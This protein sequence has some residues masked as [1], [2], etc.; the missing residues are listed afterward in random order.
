[1]R[2]GLKSGGTIQDKAKRL[3]DIK[4]DPSLIFNPKYV[5]KK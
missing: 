2:L 3:F 1:M 5:A 4:L